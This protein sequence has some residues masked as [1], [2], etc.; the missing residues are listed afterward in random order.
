MLKI[1]VVLF[2]ASSIVGCATHI[3]ASNHGGSVTESVHVKF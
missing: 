3:A 2:L 1:V